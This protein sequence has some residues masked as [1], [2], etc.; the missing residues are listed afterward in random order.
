MTSCLFEVYFKPRICHALQLAMSN[1]RQRKS[2]PRSFSQSKNLPPK[3]EGKAIKRVQWPLQDVR[4]STFIYCLAA[5][6]V[7]STL[8]YTY[9]FLQWR[10]QT[11]SLLWGL[12]FGK[13][14]SDVRSEH[15]TSGSGA[16][17]ASHELNIE[18]HINGLA[19][20]LGIKPTDLALVLSHAVRQYV[21][22]E[23]LSH[24]SSSVSA[25]GSQ[26]TTIDALF[27]EEITEDEQGSNAIFENLA[28]VV[29]V[30]IGHEE[31]VEAN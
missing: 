21:A 20:I 24:I 14:N 12:A 17:T 23:S 10:S 1:T 5:L 30:F 9:R 16:T 3:R 11:G 19:S 4:F 2:T 8:F 22:P 6:G 28:K 25:E 7:C 26:K 13:K 15:R 27:G 29:D 18:D 31:F